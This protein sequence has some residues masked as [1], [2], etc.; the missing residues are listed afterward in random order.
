MT[1]KTR[2]EDKKNLKQGIPVVAQLK[3][4]QLVSTRMQV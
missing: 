2:E 1:E 3:Q 4:I